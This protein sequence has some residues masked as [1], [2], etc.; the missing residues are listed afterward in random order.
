MNETYV[1]HAT[2]LE[3]IAA[4]HSALDQLVEMLD[5]SAFTRIAW[6]WTVKDH[7]SH[8]ALWERVSIAAAQGAAEWDVVDIDQSLWQEGRFNDI[9]ATWQQRHAAVPLADVLADFRDTHD[10]L[11][12]TLSGL[13]DADLGR[14]L[15]PASGSSRTLSDRLSGI[16]YKH[17]DLHRAAIVDALET[18]AD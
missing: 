4:S 17:Y 15:D 1:D 10:R 12:S 13:T 6:D 18:A 8:I 11:I 9:N 5:E 2:L 7:L 3:R 16:T 14:L